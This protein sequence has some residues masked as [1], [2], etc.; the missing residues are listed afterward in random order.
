MALKMCHLHFK[1]RETASTAQLT[2]STLPTKAAVK[3]GKTVDDTT[4]EHPIP[5]SKKTKLPWA[6][7]HNSR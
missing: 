3:T 6:Q 4:T 2:G 5:E 7:F 1:Q